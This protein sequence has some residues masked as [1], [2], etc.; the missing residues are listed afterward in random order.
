MTDIPAA[1]GRPKDGFAVII[2]ACR[3]DPDAVFDLRKDQEALIDQV[4]GPLKELGY[5]IH[6][7]EIQRLTKVFHPDEPAN[8]AET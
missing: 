6:S 4:Q 7:I 1:T 3:I 8:I 5:H 2:E